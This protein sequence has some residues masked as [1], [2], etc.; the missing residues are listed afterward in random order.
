M[1]SVQSLDRAL[2]ILVQVCSEKQGLKIVN[3][4][5]ISGL[6]KST[7]HRLLSTLVKHGFVEKSENSQYKAG[8]RVVELA[9][10]Y[11]NNLEL[12]TE[13][14]PFLQALANENQAAA[15]L[16]IFQDG[17][18]VYIDKVDYITD[19]RLYSQIGRRIPLHCTAVGKVLLS[20]LPDRQLAA[21]AEGITY[22]KF[23]GNTITDA[24][25]LVTQVRQARSSGVAYDM[26]EHE[27]GVVCVAAPVYDYLGHVI[28][29]V[30]VSGRLHDGLE[31]A[32]ER[33][34]DAAG[35]ISRKF[36]YRKG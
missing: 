21:A 25:A 14:Y 23:T 13:A 16:A 20:G 36:G 35:R 10:I 15:H 32:R 24:G 11:L 33:V 5:Q 29:A 31:R 18:A 6:P 28:A 17:E 26:Q 7:I 22:T 12:K 9:S 19:M 1:K 27:D 2:E 4:E 30:S 34:L 3:M 8:P